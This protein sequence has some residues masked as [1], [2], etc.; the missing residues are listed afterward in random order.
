MSTSWSQNASD[1]YAEIDRKGKENSSY[2][3][4]IEW[5]DGYRS[6]SDS[7]CNNSYQSNNDYLIF[8]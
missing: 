2:W 6:Y 5:K 1:K 4:S 3:E 8:H 7:L